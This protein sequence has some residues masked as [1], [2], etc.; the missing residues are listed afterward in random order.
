MLT[1]ITDELSRQVERLQFASPVTHVYN[2]LSYARECHHDYLRRYGS[3]HAPILLLGMNPGPFGMGQTGVPFG[4]VRATQD[5]L[6]LQGSIKQPAN[7]HPKRPVLGFDSARSEVSG[8]RLWAWAQ[9]RYGT[10]QAFFRSFFVSNYCP[11]LFLEES[12]RN[13][14]PDKLP[15][16]ERDPLFEICDRALRQTVATLQPQWVIGVGRFATT[17]AKAAL[18]DNDVNIGTILHPS[19]ASPAANR[20]WVEQAEAQLQ[21]LGIRLPARHAKVAL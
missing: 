15:K 5:W 10:P 12:G 7:M 19:P 6:K 4:E 20:G 2:P 17:R 13:R 8:R 3:F 11:L 16:H 9:Q 18:I 21:A 14:T 1:A